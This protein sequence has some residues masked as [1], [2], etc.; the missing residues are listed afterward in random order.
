MPYVETKKLN[1]VETITL[2][3]VQR[4]KYLCT[5]RGK[6]KR[7]VS[8]EKLYQNQV[9]STYKLLGDQRTRKGVD[10]KSDHHPPLDHVLV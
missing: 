7:L 8:P 10:I 5:D 3:S 9:K 2:S 4:Y 1:S 6:Q